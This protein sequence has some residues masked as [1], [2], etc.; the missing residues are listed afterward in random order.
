MPVKELSLADDPAETPFSSEVL[1]PWGPVAVVHGRDMTGARRFARTCRAMVDVAGTERSLGVLRLAFELLKRM[2]NAGVPKF[3]IAGRS[4][5]PFEQRDL[6]LPANRPAVTAAATVDDEEWQ[7]L[8]GKAAARYDDADA[9]CEPRPERFMAYSDEGIAPVYRLPGRRIIAMPSRLAAHAVE[10]AESLLESTKTR[11][12]TEARARDALNEA[13]Q[14]LSAMGCTQ[15][16]DGPW[17]RMDEH[18]AVVLHLVEEGKPQT[19]KWLIDPSTNIRQQL[20]NPPAGV[21]YAL[22][23]IIECDL[24]REWNLHLDLSDSPLLAEAKPIVLPLHALVAAADL[25]GY[26]PL[27]LWSFSRDLQAFATCNLLFRTDMPELLGLYLIRGFPNSY[28]HREYAPVPCAFAGSLYNLAHRQKQRTY[29][30]D[31]TRRQW[32]PAVCTPRNQFSKVYVTEEGPIRVIATKTARPIWLIP[33]GYNDEPPDRFL[34]ELLNAIAYWL[35]RWS[36]FE[37]DLP[38]WQA[39]PNGLPLLVSFT[40]NSINPIAAPKPPGTPPAAHVGLGRGMAFAIL[41][42]GSEDFLERQANDYEHFI[43]YALFA[44]LCERLGSTLDA[45]DRLKLVF[46]RL[47]GPHERR[48][49]MGLTGVGLDAIPVPESQSFLLRHRLRTALHEQLLAKLREQG[50]AH[51]SPPE[52]AVKDIGIL[53]TLLLTELDRRLARL[54]GAATVDYIL[55]ANECLIQERAAARI[56]LAVSGQMPA[57]DYRH[58]E[59]LRA[60]IAHADQTAPAVRWIAGYAWRKASAGTVAPSLGDYLELLELGHL[61]LNTGLFL[62]GYVK[63]QVRSPFS[64]CGP[65]AFQPVEHDFAAMMAEQQRLSESSAMRRSFHDAQSYWSLPKPPAETLPAYDDAFRDEAGMGHTDAVRTLAICIDEI[66]QTT[67]AVYNGSWSKLVSQV[68]ART[69]RPEPDIQRLL[70]WFTAPAKPVGRRGPWNTEHPDSL[71]MKPLLRSGDRLQIGAR[72][73]YHS[74]Q[75]FEML[76][77]AGRMPGS[78]DRWTRAMERQRDRDATALEKTLADFLNQHPPWRAR[79]SVS[80]TELGYEAALGD[81]DVIAVHPLGDLLAIEAKA[82]SPSL[83]PRRLDREWR[84][85]FGSK[86]SATARHKARIEKLQAEPERIARLLGVE[87]K[88]AM[89]VTGVLLTPGLPASRRWA[90]DGMLAMSVEEFEAE[91][92]LGMPPRIWEHIQKRREEEE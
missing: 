80:A 7:A 44:Q 82:L 65:D 76:C 21:M 81:Y 36:D 77:D 30:F 63:N 64:W 90:Q 22:V 67:L 13:S 83:T 39:F 41:E 72:Q 55:K 59:E 57:E 73:F 51:A 56:A 29:L 79:H 45:N 31:P 53:H 91:I 6:Q 50:L 40:R 58:T 60:T 48:L 70:D 61:Y 42:H 23:V 16:D 28:P 74:C 3:S 17:F 62:D 71:L 88:H 66:A 11:M 27:L 46:D 5:I 49:L 9:L 52:T 1:T 14:A 34:F 4:K 78:T 15:I 8:I 32:A 86:G 33:T 89:E 68:A 19:G 92:E 38:G 12:L 20:T 24:Q 84:N 25:V 69:K 10:V 75:Y 35:S 47:L 37:R 2:E 43:A 18:R 26:S 85:L 87:P 54:D